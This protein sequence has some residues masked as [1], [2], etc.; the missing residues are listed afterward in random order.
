MASFGQ[1]AKAFRQF[2][3]GEYPAHFYNPALY[4]DYAPKTRKRA[5]RKSYRIMPKYKKRKRSYKKKPRRGKRRRRGTSSASISRLRSRVSNLE[6]ITR[7]NIG[8]YVYKQRAA[9]LVNSAVSKVRHVGVDGWDINDLGNVIDAL[10][11]FDESTGTFDNVDFTSISDKQ[12]VLFQKNFSKI[13]LKNNYEAPVEV[14]LY[15][16]VPRLDTSI[17]PVNAYA[18]GLANVGIASA[19][20]STEMCYLSDSNQFRSLYRILK[21]KNRT[22][23]PGQTMELSH[24]F[25]KFAYDQSLIDNHSLD[26]QWKFRC[27]AYMIRVEGALAHNNSGSTLEYTR[28]PS[29]VDYEIFRKHVV[30]YEAGMDKETLEIVDDTATSFTD[31]GLISQLESE[32]TTYVFP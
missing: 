31:G 3:S 22:L 13:M 27:H 25:G 14:H 6:E 21:K 16:V 17:T 26:Y 5:K 24:D 4:K 19:Q 20:D 30:L 1:I 11:V 12:E 32:K 18:N 23:G 2:A 9:G 28:L 29:G 8:K 10:P 15:L 7:R